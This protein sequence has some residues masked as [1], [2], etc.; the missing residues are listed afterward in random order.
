MAGGEIAT[1][2][3]RVPSQPGPAWPAGTVGL[4]TFFPGRVLTGRA[5]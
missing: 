3:Q 2:E 1:N 4:L 5:Q